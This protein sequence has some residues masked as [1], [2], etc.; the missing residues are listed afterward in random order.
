[1]RGRQPAIVFV[2]VSDGRDRWLAMTRIAVASVRRTNP[3]L[4]IAIVCD[5]ATDLGIRDGAHGIRTAVDAWFAVDVG[6]GTPH[7]LHRKL[8]QAVPSVVDG[9]FLLLDGDVVVRGSLAPI[10]AA[11]GDIAA[12]RNHSKPRLRDQITRGD[13][14]VL[15]TM[16]WR[17]RDDVYVNGGVLYYAGTPAARALWDAWRA[18]WESSFSRTDYHVDQPALNAALFATGTNLAI[19]PDAFNAQIATRPSAARDAAIWHYYA[20]RNPA[21]RKADHLLPEMLTDQLV[22]GMPLTDDAL[23]AVIAAEAPWRQGGRYDRMVVQLLLRTGSSAELMLL[24]REFGRYAARRSRDATSLL[25]QAGRRV[26]NE[27]RPAR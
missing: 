4:P 14:G 2:L 17:T 9:A 15:E 10:F 25:I 12:A 6:E 19:L 5:T 26:A 27:F 20:S 8:K 11:G 23:A 16:Q 13:R 22:A 3:G 1:M 24:R 18:H 21:H 7:C